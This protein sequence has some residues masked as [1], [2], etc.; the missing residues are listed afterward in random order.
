MQLTIRNMTVADSGI[1]YC[2]AQNSFG[3]YAQVMK[4]QA[5]QKAVSSNLFVLFF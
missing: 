2:N 1:Y 3:S 4:L 5:R